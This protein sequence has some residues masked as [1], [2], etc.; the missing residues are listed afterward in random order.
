MLNLSGV[1]KSYGKKQ[2]LA[3][4]DLHVESGKI[5]V[6]I[7]PSGCGKSTLLRLMIGLIAPDAGR[8]EF[9]GIDLS[10]ADIESLRHKM[11]Y[12][13]Q[14]GGLFPH[15]TAEQ[16][17][18]LLARHLNWKEEAVRARMTELAEL[19]HFPVEGLD[20]YPVQLSGGQ[21]QRVSLMRALM[22]DPDLLLLDEPLGALDPLIRTDLQVELREIFA[23]LK[24][25]VVLV[26]HDI[27][28]AGFFG[29]RIILM[30]EGNIVQSGTLDE[31]VNQPADPFVTRFINA[32]RS[33]LAA[34]SGGER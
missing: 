28:E 32:Q 11:G 13:I 6:L 12:V 24:K 21:R 19:T 31:L 23:A 33:P 18:G 17:V 9:E 16:N 20:R 30:R 26:T 29:D 8:I 5:T 34:L 25:T 14:D 2:V 4:T 27:G 10:Q 7:G 1:S 15:L 22:L 3:P